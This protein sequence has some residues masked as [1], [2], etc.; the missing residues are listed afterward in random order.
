MN[1][2]GVKAWITAHK[3][4][5]AGGG[6]AVA[7]A[8]YALFKRHQ[9]NAATGAGSPSAAGVVGATGVDQNGNPYVTYPATAG[10]VSPDTTSTDLGN[11]LQD[12]LNAVNGISAGNN[13]VGNANAGTTT[14]PAVSDSVLNQLR[15]QYDTL[16]G[17]YR[18]YE[19]LLAKTTDP[20]AR[21]QLQALVS[22]K[23]AAASAAAGAYRAAL[24]ANGVPAPTTTT[25]T[26]AAPAPA[27]K[28]AAQPAALRAPITT[29]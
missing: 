22:T 1:L 3:G 24:T 25:K 2:D 29:T 15:T 9:A 6:A 21:A 17:E 18:D 23:G 10:I 13:T 16:V 26:P 27:P 11:Q 8:G 14:A 20:K 5:A 28:P 4:P 12:V 7:V 19:G